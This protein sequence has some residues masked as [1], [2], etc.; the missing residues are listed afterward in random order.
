MVELYAGWRLIKTRSGEQIAA[1][2]RWAAQWKA[3]NAR[4]PLRTE[5]SLLKTM[6]E[7]ADPIKDSNGQIIGEKSRTKMELLSHVAFK[8]VDEMPVPE[9]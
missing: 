3:K 1:R 5:M 8:A 4:L 6:F 9:G 2:E 7:V